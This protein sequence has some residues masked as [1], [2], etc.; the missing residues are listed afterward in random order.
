MS[1]KTICCVCGK[2]L[3][4]FGHNPSPVPELMEWTEEEQRCCVDCNQTFVIP[5]RMFCNTVGKL[6]EGANHVN[7]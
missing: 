1:N 6:R 7:E 3:E 4:G 2:E 5:L